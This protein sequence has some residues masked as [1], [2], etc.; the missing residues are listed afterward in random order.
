MLGKL[1]YLS[2]GPN[3]KIA[4]VIESGVTMRLVELLM[5]PSPAV[6]TPALKTIGNL[7]SGDDLQTQIVI[8]CSVLPNLL[9][10]L[11]SVKIG[12]KKEACWTIGNITA[13]NKDQIQAVIEAN[14]I[15]P[16]VHLL[17][18][19]EFDIKKEAAWAISNATSGGTPEQIEYL[20]QR[21][22]IPPLCDLLT[23]QD[24]KIV[25]VALEGL[26]NILKVGETAMREKGLPINPCARVLVVCSGGQQHMAIPL[27]KIAALQQHE[28]V[29]VYE[30][31][32]KILKSYFGACW[33]W[34]GDSTTVTTRLPHRVTKDYWRDPIVSYA[35]LDIYQ[36][37]LEIKKIFPIMYGHYGFRSLML[38]Y[39]FGSIKLLSDGTSK[40]LQF[41]KVYKSLKSNVDTC[42]I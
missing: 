36:R 15:P 29:G 25:T 16:L 41:F 38:D 17:S 4:A 33:Y 6:Q 5:H 21:G 22:C 30:K 20:V 35:L 11:S 28:D 23:V 3:E 8:N 9:S 40:S 42:E 34:C 12:I 31:S 10:L 13:G 32:L 7:V 14:I 37:L 1:S 2:D 19:A 24:N 27:D 18:H 39:L 26:E